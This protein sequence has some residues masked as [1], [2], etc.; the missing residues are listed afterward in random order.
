[1]NF[2]KNSENTVK[3]VLTVKASSLVDS[4]IKTSH[5]VKTSYYLHK[6]FVGEIVL[7]CPYAPREELLKPWPAMVTQIHKSNKIDLTVFTVYGTE[8][9]FL[10][11]YSE[12]FQSN[13]WSWLKK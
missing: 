11:P 5:T 1:M 6:T 4:T 13:H 10:V 7:Y 8:T 3:D 2:D 12:E 9:R